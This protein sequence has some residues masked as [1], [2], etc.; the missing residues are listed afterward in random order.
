MVHACRTSPPIQCC[1]FGL[2]CQGSNEQ[3]VRPSLT[4]LVSRLVLSRRVCAVESGTEDVFIYIPKCSSQNLKSVGKTLIRQSRPRDSKRASRPGHLNPTQT[5]SNSNSK[6]S[7]SL[8]PQPF[9]FP[10]LSFLFLALP[11]SFPNLFTALETSARGF[12]FETIARLETR[13]VC[14]S[15]STD[16][17]AEMASERV[18]ASSL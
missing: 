8:A 10:F 14:A 2:L 9:S 15:R 5:N 3:N 17:R 11:F 1:F 16:K 6:V 7:S 12:C 4:G 13:L 18:R